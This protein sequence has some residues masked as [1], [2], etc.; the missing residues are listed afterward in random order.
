MG[1]VAG[2]LWEALQWFASRP[3]ASLHETDQAAWR[4]IYDKVDAISNLTN[5]DFDAAFVAP[6]LL[7][8]VRAALN[9]AGRPE[10][11]DEAIGAGRPYVEAFSPAVAMFGGVNP[12]LTRSDVD[13][14]C[15]AIAETA[16]GSDS[17][18]L[19]ELVHSIG[20]GLGIP[21]A[22]GYSLAEM[23]LT[24]LD[25]PGRLDWIDI[26]DVVRRLGV[27]VDEI[28]L[29][30]DSIRG[31]AIAGEDFEPR[32]L[33]NTASVFNQSENG[34]RFTIAHELCHVLH[35]R[36]RARR[37]RAHKRAMGRAQS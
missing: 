23:F 9:R 5:F 18:L 19:R 6:T 32:I 20:G 22:E 15:Q 7:T 34:K 29:Q 11:A 2:P 8:E 26:R 13:A 21:Y 25:L 1:E 4:A 37:V 24:D 31:V 28:T 30:S 16:G 36:S 12:N 27:E 33:L 35:D 17:K 3:P 14:L 10:L